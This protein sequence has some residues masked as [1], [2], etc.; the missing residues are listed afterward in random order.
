MIHRH[1]L[2]GVESDFHSPQII[3]FPA[4]DQ[5]TIVSPNRGPWLYDVNDDNTSLRV[6][7]MNRKSSKN[8]AYVFVNG[9][10]YSISKEKILSRLSP[11]QFQISTFD[12]AS[13]VQL[14]PELSGPLKCSLSFDGSAAAFGSSDG[15]VAFFTDLGREQHTPVDR[16]KRKDPQDTTA[17][18]PTDLIQAT[19]IIKVSDKPISGIAVSTDGKI[20]AVGS[21][22]NTMRILDTKSMTVVHEERTFDYPPSI[23]AIS[24]D[25]NFLACSDNRNMLLIPLAKLKSKPVSSLQPKETIASIA[26][27]ESFGGMERDIVQVTSY[28]RVIAISMEHSKEPSVLAI[29]ALDSIT[30]S[31]DGQFLCGYDKKLSKIFVLKTDNP[32]EVVATIAEPDVE[33]VG[34]SPKKRCVVCFSKRGGWSWSAFSYDGSVLWQGVLTAYPIREAPIFSQSG[35]LVAIGVGPNG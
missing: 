23:L 18:G 32:S 29:P 24:N 30:L 8:L 12:G 19:K 33:F 7:T 25:S 17:A 28:N 6:S 22:D 35:E 1:Q 3:P 27:R 4:F 10:E 14:L 11:T 15:R 31:S 20:M 21:N 9:F 26:I 5:G 34:F 2:E 13:S 16:R